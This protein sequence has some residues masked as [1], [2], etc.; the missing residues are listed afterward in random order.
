MVDIGQIGVGARSLALGKAYVGSADDATSIFINPA[1]LA[2]NDDFNITSMSGTILSDINYLMIGV[3]DYSPMG[4][5][6]FGYLNASVGSIPIT[7]ITGSGSTA[8]VVQTGSTDYSSS[9][10]FFSYGTQLSKIFNGKGE[11]IS[12]GLNVKYFLQGFTGGGGALQE[13]IG[14][15]MD[16]DMG[17]I[18]RVR[19]WARLGF[20]FNNFLPMDFGGRFIWRK[21]DEMESIYRVL[22]AGGEF[23]I[24]GK[25]GIRKYN[26]QELRL[27]LDYETEREPGR[28]ATWHTGLEYRPVKILALRMGMDQKARATTAGAGV[29]NNFTF[30]V[31]IKY[32]GFTF[33]YAFQ[34][35][36]EL[37]ENGAQF[38][39][40]GFVGEEE[41]PKFKEKKKKTEAVVPR[42]VVVP[43]PELK[44]FTDLPDKY[45]AKKPIEY[46]ATLNI[47]GGY[48]DQTFRPDERLTRGQLAVIL[49]KAKEFST[50]GVAKSS[51]KDV[52]AYSWISPYIEVAVAR[53]Y[54]K[55][56]P[57]GVFAPYKE[58]SRAEAAVIFSRFAGLYVKP[59]VQGKVFP[60]LKKLHWASPAVA[61]TKQAGFLEYLSGKDFDAKK[62]LTRAE[63]AEMLSKTPTVK[64][65]IKKL[66]AGEK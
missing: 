28:P 56:Y 57:D 51:F 39:S 49:V 21:N 46:L 43:K 34:Q 26:N 48:P 33:D 23:T 22:R 7:A 31:G 1:G 15:G 63:A 52:N 14:A 60:D 32:L 19:P 11:D 38:F 18:W 66:L 27:L 24:L 36:G 42:P 59:K 53:G 29:D 37:S 50:V 30:G 16:A 12:F 9:I 3:S 61:A 41:E 44:T 10:L 5:F 2:L 40:I 47:M 58:V 35:M 55:G 17:L 20:T 64:A 13:A 8:A 62:A 4:K 45:W 65:K 54:M 6:G 25:N